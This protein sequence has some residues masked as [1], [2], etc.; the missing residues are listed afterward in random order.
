MIASVLY[1]SPKVLLKYF[2]TVHLYSLKQNYF[3][4]F[5][6]LKQIFLLSCILQFIWVTWV[7]GYVLNLLL[8][9]SLKIKIKV[10]IYSCFI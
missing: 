2:C 7:E 10:L 3:G 9:S 1:I 5:N 8:L 6:R 4:E